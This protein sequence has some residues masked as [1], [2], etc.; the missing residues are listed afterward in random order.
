MALRSSADRCPT[1]QAGWDGRIVGADVESL[2]SDQLDE[3]LGLQGVFEDHGHLAGG[4]LGRDQGVDSLPGDEA[5]MAK[6]QRLCPHRL[7]EVT[8]AA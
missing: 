2:G 1:L 3:A 5:M 8:P 6:A 4:L 7:I